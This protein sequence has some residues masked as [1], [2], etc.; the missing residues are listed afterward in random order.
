MFSMCISCP[1]P[2]SGISLRA[3]VFLVESRK[4]GPQ[5][6][7]SVLKAALQSLFRGFSVDIIKKNVSLFF[8]L[9]TPGACGNTQASDQS[10]ATAVS[11]A[12]ALPEPDPEPAEP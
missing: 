11:K 9:A 10:H 2:G 8:F 4:R 6:V 1:R 12:T 3:S 5:S 7:Q